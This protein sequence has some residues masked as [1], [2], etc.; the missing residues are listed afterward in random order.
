MKCLTQKIFYNPLTTVARLGE[1]LVGVLQNIH[2]KIEQVD[3]RNYYKNRG[4]I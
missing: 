1:S 4:E 3:M 2:N